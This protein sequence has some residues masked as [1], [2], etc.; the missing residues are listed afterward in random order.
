MLSVATI[1][2]GLGMLV[3]TIQ[4]VG[5]PAAWTAAGAAYKQ[6]APAV[7]GPDPASTR[8]S[9]AA[10]GPAAAARCWR[11]GGDRSASL[12]PP[13]HLHLQIVQLACNQ[14]EKLTVDGLRLSEICI[15]VPSVN[16]GARRQTLG[17][18]RGACG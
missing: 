15:Q 5:H 16:N 2:F 4:L 10:L 8:A 6:Q 17:P 3:V 13:V 1:L 14:L 11:A 9:A 18:C 12:A 7:V